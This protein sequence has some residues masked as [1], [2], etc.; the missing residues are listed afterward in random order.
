MPK[1]REINMFSTKNDRPKRACPRAAR[2]LQITLITFFTLAVSFLFVVY[3]TAPAMYVQVLLGRG[4]NTN[5]RPAYLTAF[6]VAILLLIVLLVVG[7]LRRWRW[8]FWLV[9]AAFIAE[10]IALPID[11]LQLA[12]VMPLMYPVWYTIVRLAVSSLQIAI[13][14]WMIWLYLRCGVWAMGS[15]NV[16]A[17]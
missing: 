17:G 7:V 13:G 16:V 11:A 15:K 9:M 2:A 6:L 4:A 8:L 5:T 12:G 10:M 14:G 3:I 1:G